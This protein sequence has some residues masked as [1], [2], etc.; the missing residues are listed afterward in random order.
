[1]YLIFVTFELVCLHMLLLYDLCTVCSVCTIMIFFCI[2]LFFS[3]KYFIKT[4]LCNVGI[5]Y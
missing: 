3:L 4:K 2:V 5:I 1:V